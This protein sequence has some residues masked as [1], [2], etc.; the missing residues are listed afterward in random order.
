MAVVGLA[1]TRGGG[2]EAGGAGGDGRE[3]RVV[4][5]RGV[6]VARPVRLARPHGEVE[7]RGFRPLAQLLLQALWL[8][9]VQLS[10][11]VQ[12]VC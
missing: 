12:V 9:L 1:E 5:V 7:R 10:G 2:G 3:G 8:R 11:A 4:L 6:V